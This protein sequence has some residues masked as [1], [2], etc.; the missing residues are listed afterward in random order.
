MLVGEMGER[1]GKKEEKEKSVFPTSMRTW[2][3]GI[4]LFI[5]NPQN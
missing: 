3:L 4:I 1:D 5:F 2:R